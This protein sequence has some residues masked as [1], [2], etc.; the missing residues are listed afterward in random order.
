MSDDSLV[1]IAANAHRDR[2]RRDF[3]DRWILDPLRVEPATKMPKFCVDGHS[4]TVKQIYD[5]D[6]HRQFNA[7]WQYL[8]TIPSA[9]T[10]ASANAKAGR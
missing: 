4:T 10:N 2:L 5:G 7:I 1:E 3:Y 9:E 8:Q 6:A